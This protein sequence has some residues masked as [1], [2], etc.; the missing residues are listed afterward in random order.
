M[1]PGLRKGAVGLVMALGR[2][3]AR[4]LFDLAVSA[5]DLVLGL[6]DT[7]AIAC[8]LKLTGHL[9]AAVK[10]SDLRWME[11]EVRCLATVMGWPQC[12]G[13]WTR[14]R[15]RALAAAAG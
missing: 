14:R 4:A 12:P 2:E 11:E 10:A 3:R 9:L 6:I 15:R 5:R 7:H 1:I 8:D 13:F